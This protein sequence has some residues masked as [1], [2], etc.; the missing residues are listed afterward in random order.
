[1]KFIVSFCR[2]GH[3]TPQR[4]LYPFPRKAFDIDASWDDLSN[5]LGNRYHSGW[6][7]DSG[8]PQ[9]TRGTFFRF[10]VINFLYHKL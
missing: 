9:E 8:L 10:T 1:M 6:L 7:T 2:F 4:K 3:K 5:D